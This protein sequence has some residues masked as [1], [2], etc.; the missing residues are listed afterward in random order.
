MG[1]LPARA[2]TSTTSI[3]RYQAGD[4]HRLWQAWVSHQ[5]KPELEPEVIYPQ[6]FLANLRGQGYLF[7]L[8][9]DVEAD[10]AELKSDPFDPTPVKVMALSRQCTYWLP[11]TVPYGS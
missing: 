1:R 11:L 7:R 9:I 2:I 8:A 3:T 6:Q 10:E 5:G 4:T